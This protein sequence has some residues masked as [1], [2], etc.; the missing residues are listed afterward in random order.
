MEIEVGFGILF[1]EFVNRIVEIIL[2]KLVVF[3]FF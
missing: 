3:L 2:I 1:G